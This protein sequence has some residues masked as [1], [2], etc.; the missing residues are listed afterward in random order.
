MPHTP[1]DPPRLVAPLPSS[2][3]PQDPNVPNK[4]RN[5]ASR[6]S[7]PET[8][9]SCEANKPSS[10]SKCPQLAIR[11]SRRR[12]RVVGLFSTLCVVGITGGLATLILGWICAFHDSLENGGGI[13]SVLR[14]GSFAIVEPSTPTEFL[15]SLTQTETLRILMFSALAVS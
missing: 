2:M 12:F 1:S 8:E 3:I 10:P 14:N 4:P 15:F 9:R 13:L 6:S 11:T 7:G 5:T